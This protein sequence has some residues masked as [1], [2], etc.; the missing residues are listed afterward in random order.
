MVE[1]SSLFDTPEIY[2][3]SIHKRLE[4]TCLMTSKYAHLCRLTTEED[5]LEKNEAAY[6][7]MNRAVSLKG[8]RVIGQS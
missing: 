6:G 2:N 3:T 7:P 1:A 8:N 4:T 5:A